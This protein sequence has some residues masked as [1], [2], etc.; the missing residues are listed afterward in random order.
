MSFTIDRILASARRF[1]RGRFRLDVTRRRLCFYRPIALQF[2]FKLYDKKATRATSISKLSRTAMTSEEG[3][4]TS[5][6]EQT[7][8]IPIGS[9]EPTSA[10]K[11]APLG[12]GIIQIKLLCRRTWTGDGKERHPLIYAS[13]HGF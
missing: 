1:V 8:L 5:D 11:V 12:G 2:A 13:S 6:E 10:E 3:R 4:L 7:E 9:K